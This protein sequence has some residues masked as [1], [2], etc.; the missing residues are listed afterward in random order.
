VE[1]DDLAMHRELVVPQDQE[2]IEALGT[3]PEQS[4]DSESARVLDIPINSTERLVFS[5]DT[6]GRSVRV[7]WYD[8][9]S[10]RLDLFREGACQ[11]S[12]RTEGG[13]TLI[14]VR[15]EI[16]GVA[17]NLKLQV[18]PVVAIDDRL[19]FR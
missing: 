15:F 17:G 8:E 3:A 7:K 2:L 1:V 19:L 14:S 5:Y 10:L 4:G 9:D 12:L 16:E 13:A 18:Y 6:I 11:I